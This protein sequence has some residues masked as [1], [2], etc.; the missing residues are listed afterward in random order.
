M[1]GERLPRAL[2]LHLPLVFQQILERAPLVDELRGAL[3]AD[4]LDAGNVVARVA[5]KRAQIENSV[6]RHAKARLDPGRVVPT[7]ANAIEQRDPVGHELHQ[8]LVGGDDRHP[9]ARR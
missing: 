2:G 3:F 4:A 1:L 7:V 6:R 5:H 9:C 8:V